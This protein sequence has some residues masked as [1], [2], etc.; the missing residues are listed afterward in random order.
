MDW[1]ALG[2]AFFI[3]V[4]FVGSAVAVP[5]AQLTV[6]D[7]TVGDAVAGEPV[8]ITPTIQSSVGSDQAVTID[9]VNATIDG[10]E[11]AEVTNEG[12]LSPGDDVSVPIT[13]TFEKPGEYTV[14]FLV[15][16]TD[17][18]GERVTVTREET[19]VVSP[20][21][22]VRLTVADVAVAPETPTVG[23]P[24]TV[25]VTVDSS[26]GSSQP[27]TVD[28]IALLDGEE[29]LAE[30]SGV[31]SLAVG[32][33]I[34]V[35][36]TTT[37]ETAGVKTLSTELRGT[38]ANDESVVVN[39]PVT[40]VVEAGAPAIEV[41]NLS[42]V[43]GTGTEVGVAVSN[44]TE[45]TLRDVV[46]TVGGPGLE[47]EVDRRVVPSLSPGET[48]DLSFR[49]RPES[50]GETLLETNVSYRTGTGTTADRSVTDVMTV[51][52][53]AEAVSV[54]VRTV[55]GEPEQSQPDLGVGVEGVL[56]TDVGEEATGSEGDLRVTVSNLGNAIVRNVVLDPQAGGQSLGARPIATELAPGAEE[57]AVVTLERTPP[58]ELVFEV[59]YDVANSSSSSAATYDP[60]AGRGTVSVTGVD[61]ETNGEQV[62]ITG[63]IGNP[64][65]GDIS[66]VVVAVG[67]AEDVSP[68]YPSRDFFVGQ[69][70][71]NGFAPFE[72]TATAG[73]NATHVPLTVQYLVDGDE[74][75][76]TVELPIEEPPDGNGGGGPSTLLIA[77]VFVG[78]LAVLTT[79]VVFARRA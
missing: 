27:L 47:G 26:A 33:A 72:L 57:S 10:E 65:E 34:T 71:G 15:V 52:P 12:T 64:G 17:E 30:A 31:G 40:L 77:A 75:T 3:C 49:V 38:N 7:V 32:D 61:L 78:L 1:R 25:P 43:E 22:A 63:D 67:S 28:S 76:E 4:V 13:T 55:S 39:Q 58:G 18:D 60:G 5:N 35:P 8:T 62:E 59:T 14:E 37:F 24:V 74:R 44:P 54:R 2:M 56:D 66:G 79:I 69:I 21:P 36:L 68:S 19:V 45:G 11:I 42:A 16:G 9:T 70:E 6:S 23:A 53:L 29:P 46:A 51:E 41:G 20:V 73:E 50:A 48:A